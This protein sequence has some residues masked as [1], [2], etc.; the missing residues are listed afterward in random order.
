[1]QAPVAQDWRS[2]ELDELAENF[3]LLGDWDSRYQYVI[4]LGNERLPPLPES[5]RG[6]QN[7]VRGC[8][9]T[10]YIAASL[11]DVGGVQYRGECNTDIMRGVI[12]ILF[13]AC[14]GRPA[15]FC[16][17]FDPDGLFEHLN[18]FD[19]LSPTRHVGTYAIAD[20]MNRLAGALS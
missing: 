14:N 12:A 20:H 15:D 9:S 1:M 5:D 16:A 3:E 18:L 4:E 6:E 17:E 8:T 10:V 7:L 13:M 11:D 2:E 19:H